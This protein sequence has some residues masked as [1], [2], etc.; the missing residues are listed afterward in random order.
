[1]AGRGVLLAITASFLWSFTGPGI[2]Y[3]LTVYHVPRLTLAFWRDLFAVLVLLPLTLRWFGLPQRADLLRFAV[4]GVFASACIMRC[5]F[6]RWRTMA[7]PL[8][9]C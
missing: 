2:G 1:M 7:P 3:L 6:S 9:L 4:V 8:R 5:G